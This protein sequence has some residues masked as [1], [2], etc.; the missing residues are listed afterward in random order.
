MS[1][2]VRKVP[3]NE[4]EAIRDVK[5]L[6]ITLDALAAQKIHLNFWRQ[7]ASRTNRVTRELLDGIF[8]WCR[9]RGL[10]P[11]KFVGEHISKVREVADG[12]GH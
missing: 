9:R 12:Q 10:D 5:N 4:R 2:R 11:V 6:S 8:T 3:E 1:K 7:T